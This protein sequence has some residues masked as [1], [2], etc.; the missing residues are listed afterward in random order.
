M[1]LFYE[2]ETEERA[3]VTTIHYKPELL[4]LEAK[5]RGVEVDQLP[6]KPVLGSGEREVLY[7]NPQ[8]DELWY[9]V[10][11]KSH[12]VEEEVK[13]IKETVDM[14]ILDSLL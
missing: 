2:V 8:T 13:S 7:M 6:V 12:P 5:S 3:R 4:T 14:L 9:E 11:N 1:V 10:I